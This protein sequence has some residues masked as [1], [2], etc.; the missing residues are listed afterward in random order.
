MATARTR[1]GGMFQHDVEEIYD[2]Y[3]LLKKHWLQ[4]FHMRPLIINSVT[5]ILKLLIY[6]CKVSSSL[7]QF[8]HVASHS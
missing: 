8:F 4:T 2:H 3:T 6:A 1:D 7:I 5:F